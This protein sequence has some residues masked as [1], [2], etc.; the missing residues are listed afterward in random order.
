MADEKIAPKKAKK[1]R[2]PRDARDAGR[3]YPPFLS[4]G[5][6]AVRDANC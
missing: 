1:D 6:E 3:K 4:D 5:L 2:N